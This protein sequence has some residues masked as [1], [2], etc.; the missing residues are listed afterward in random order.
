[1]SAAVS[2]AP[3][4][5][6]PTAQ[7]ELARDMLLGQHSVGFTAEHTGLSVARVDQMAQ[8]LRAAKRIPKV[9]P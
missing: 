4:A 7:R 2:S 8:A 6:S 5:L 3:A 9:R 1:V